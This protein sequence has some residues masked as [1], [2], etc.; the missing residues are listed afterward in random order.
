[1]DSTLP[2]TKAHDTLSQDPRAWH[3]SFQQAPDVPEALVAGR[4][5]MYIVSFFKKFSYNPAAITEADV[6]EYARAYSQPGAMRAG[7]EWYRSFPTDAANNR[8][9]F[10]RK[11]KMPLL[12][13]NGNPT[14]EAQTESYVAVMMRD[15]AENVR[16]AVIPQSGHYLAEEQPEVLTKHL[17]EFL[18]K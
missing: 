1:M 17:L 7:F 3:F 18:G 10:K 8:E 9:S 14:T 11:L 12:A 6:D 4:E 15:G 13:I 16:G 2:G 5:R